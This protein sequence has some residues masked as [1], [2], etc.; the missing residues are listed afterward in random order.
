VAKY[1]Q[2]FL[3]DSRKLKSPPRIDGQ[4]GAGARET[5]VLAVALMVGTPSA[6]TEL[7]G[8]DPPNC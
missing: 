1:F 3:E 5:G 4:A 2:T 6:V 7:P 8:I